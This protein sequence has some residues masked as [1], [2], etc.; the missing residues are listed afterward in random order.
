MIFEN[1]KVENLIRDQFDG[2]TKEVLEWESVSNAVFLKD[3]FRKESLNNEIINAY[4][5]ASKSLFVALDRDNNPTAGIKLLKSNQMCMPFL[6]L[7]RH[8]V[9]LA[10]KHKYEE[11]NSKEIS[12]HKLSDLWRNVKGYLT[13]TDKAVSGMTEFITALDSIDSDGCQLRYS[14]SKDGEL[15]KKTPIFIKA[16]KIIQCTEE[17]VKLMLN[18]D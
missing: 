18:K 10:I 17:F 14:A 11:K 4:L 9:E 13:Q 5:N 1:L 8:T 2:L 15:Y 16:D 3:K 12:G 7:C 6:F